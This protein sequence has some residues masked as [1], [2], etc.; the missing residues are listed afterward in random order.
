M[1]SVKSRHS[2]PPKVAEAVNKSFNNAVQM[3]AQAGLKIRDNIKVSVDPELPF[4][5]YTMPEG[6]SFQIVVSGGAVGSGMLE[7]LLVHEMSHVYRIQTNHPSH[8]AM[9]LEEV[10]EKLQSKSRHHDYQQ[11]ILHDLLNDIQDLYADD[12]AFRVLRA[13]PTRILD[14]IPEFLQGMVV[15]EPVKSEDKVKDRW[16]NASIMVHNARAIAQMARDRVEDAGGRA[17]ESNRRFL[18]KVPAD[19]APKFPLFGNRLVSLKE[20]ITEDEY[21]TLLVQHL[22]QFVE[23]AEAK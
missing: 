17:A 3:M 9:I 10:I 4:M 23:L 12:L 15:D 8:N 20:E 18:D 6:N 5:G 1:P 2:I 19:F 14:K 11:R 21:R 7:G 13:S 22:N 16:V